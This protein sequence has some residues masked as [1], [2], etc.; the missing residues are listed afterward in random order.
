MLLTPCTMAARAGIKKPEHFNDF[1]PHIF[2]VGDLVVC[3]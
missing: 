3:W 1:I 2:S